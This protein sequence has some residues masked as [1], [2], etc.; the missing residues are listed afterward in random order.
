[1]SAV[2]SKDHHTRLM[3]EEVARLFNTGIDTVKAML[4]AM[5]QYGIQTAIHPMMHQLHVDH[6][7]LHQPRLVGM[8]FLGT[9]MAKVKSK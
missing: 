2:A 5:T 3:I 8:W 6:L 1:M 7:N 9:L 4:E